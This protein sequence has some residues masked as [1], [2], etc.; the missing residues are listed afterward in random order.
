MIAPAWGA[1]QSGHQLTAVAQAAIDVLAVN[2]LL[3]KQSPDAGAGL[4]PVIAAGI[5]ALNRLISTPLNV[6]FAHRYNSDR[7]DDPFGPP[8][9]HDDRYH[10]GLNGRLGMGGIPFGLG[11]TGQHGPLRTQL[12][13]GLDLETFA[14]Y[15]Q[16]QAAILAD[17]RP[18]YGLVGDYRIK[19][20][21]A[22]RLRP[23]I[24]VKVSRM[25]VAPFMGPPLQPTRWVADLSPR[26][27]LEVLG[28]SRFSVEASVGYAAWR[29]QALT[30]FL[31][32]ADR[33]D[34]RFGH[35]N[36][37]QTSRLMVQAAAT[38]WVW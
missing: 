13:M 29:S 36:Q 28:Y 25:R 34:S 38:L 32:E 14:Q 5:F 35:A 15:P 27:G 37:A 1:W 19:L 20:G 10:L 17:L 26:I 9:F 6:F 8:P 4:L 3:T 11:I 21:K 31:E 12:Q 30:D 22:V 24:E 18:T 23:G 7:V 33:L 16:D 2:L